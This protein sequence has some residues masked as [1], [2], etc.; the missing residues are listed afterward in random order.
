MLRLAGV[1]QLV[2]VCLEIIG[3][4]AGSTPGTQMWQDI[5]TVVPGH[6]LKAQT[7]RQRRCVTFGLVDDAKVKGCRGILWTMSG[8]SRIRAAR[9]TL[10]ASLGA[11][12]P[13]LLSALLPTG[14]TWL[15]FLKKKN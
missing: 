15:P 4:N 7:V 8:V 2:R 12:R 9:L 6:G 5:D 3:H 10:T 14:S 13:R 1:P 11:S